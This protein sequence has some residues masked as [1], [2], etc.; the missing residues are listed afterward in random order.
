[1]R[2]L[3]RGR[4][5]TPSTARAL[6]RCNRINDALHPLLNAEAIGPD[7]V[8]YHRLSRDLVRDILIRPRPPRL[9]VELSERMSVRSGG[10]RW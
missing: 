5:A 10:P 6:A 3:I 4:S 9:A 8:R 7:Q 2:E 1:M